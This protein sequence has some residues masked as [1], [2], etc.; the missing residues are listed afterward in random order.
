MRKTVFISKAICVVLIIALL[1]EPM[2][3]KSVKASS[4]P[5]PAPT[6][7]P[8]QPAGYPDGAKIMNW[9]LV[10]SGKHLDWSSSSKYSTAINN[11]ISIWEGY[12]KGVIRKDGLFKVRDVLFSDMLIIPGYPD[13][14][15]VTYPDGRIMF[16]TYYME[17]YIPQT[18]THIAAHEIGHALGLDDRGEDM[19]RYH[20]MYY[21]VN[22]IV[23][24]CNLEKKTYDYLY[25][26]VY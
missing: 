22:F 5:V 13:A 25:D 12:K 26:N 4:E 11:G 19:H 14:A 9:D 17:Q 20:M 1:L 15:A 10:D 7:A 6:P 23:T 18:Q 3:F 21:K 24:L 2:N 16:A 8:P